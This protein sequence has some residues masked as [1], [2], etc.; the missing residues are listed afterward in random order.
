MDNLLNQ[1]YRIL[2]A[3][4]IIEIWMILG[5]LMKTY[6]HVLLWKINEHSIFMGKSSQLLIGHDWVICTIAMLVY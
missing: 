2:Y 6:E 5:Y 1:I 4:H 3:Y